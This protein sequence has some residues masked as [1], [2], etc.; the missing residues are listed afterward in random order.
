MASSATTQFK[1]CSKFSGKVRIVAR[2]RGFRDQE[3]ASDT[4]RSSSIISVR[5]SGDSERSEKVIL[6]FDDQTSS[7]KNEYEV[8]HC[9]GQNEDTTLIFSK[10]IKPHIAKAFDGESSTFIAFGARGSGKTYLMQGSEE[11]HGLGMMVMDEILKSLG[12]KHSVAVSIYE[13]FQNHVYDLLDSKNPEVHVLEDAQGNIKFKGLSELPVKSMLEFQKLYCGGNSLSKQ[14]QKITLEVPRRSHKALMVHILASA[15]GTNQKCIGKMN[16]VDLAGY[17]NPRRNS[18]NATNF[19]EGIQINKSL[20]ALLK[21]IH[22]V[23]A[24]EIRIPYRESKVARMLQDSLGGDNHISLL[25][26]VNPLFCPDTVYAVALASRLKDIEPV[27]FSLS[28]KKTSTS[29]VYSSANKA[30][31]GVN[32]SFSAKKTSTS[33]VHLSANK[34]TSGVSSAVFSTIT[35]RTK[36]RLALSAMKTKND[37]GR[38]VSAGTEEANGIKEQIL[39]TESC[40]SDGVIFNPNVVDVSSAIVLVSPKEEINE[41]GGTQEIES[42]A[43][44]EEDASVTMPINFTESI[45]LVNG[46][47]VE[48]ENNSLTF[49]GQSPPS[50]GLKKILDRL[51]SLEVNNHSQTLASGL[52]YAITEDENPVDTLEPKTPLVTYK[53]DSSHCLSGTFS[54]R[55]S[56]MKQSLVQDYL[57]FLNSASK[58]ELKRIRGIGDKRAE[59]ILE[60]R[61]ESPEPFKSLD[62]LQDIGLSAKQVKSMMKNLAGDLFS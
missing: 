1:H 48:K 12:E 11:N 7:R 49:N 45:P 9:Y 28:T 43:M 34:A 22:A 42:I 2:V 32:T 29:C 54:K 47:N 35:K 36:S 24:Y 33:R 14:T 38:D 5:K 46:D 15:E 21:V 37:K 41:S 61:E 19:I 16:F 3:L 31:S 44:N 27:A 25:V 40:S 4:A 8:D 52:Q 62:D 30:K 60:L 53:S 23:N 50:L 13:V 58:D 59:Y 56:G 55:S 10:E 39:N 17:E 18:I 51:K 26:C 20:N 6:S 57:H